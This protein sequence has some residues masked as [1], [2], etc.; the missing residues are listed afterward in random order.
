[1]K[2]TAAIG[3]ALAVV[4]LAACGST[5][6]PTA[7]PSTPTTPTPLLIS[8][9][10]PASSPSPSAPTPRPTPTP[11]PLPPSPPAQPLAMFASQANGNIELVNSQGKA[12]VMTVAQMQ[13]AVGES[14]ADINRE[15]DPT[16]EAAGPNILL[17]YLNGTPTA[18][19]AVISGSTGKLLGRGTAPDVSGQVVG[20]PSGTEWVWIQEIGVN[21]TGHYWGTVAIAGLGVSPHT[22]FNWTAPAGYN[23][24]LNYWTDAGIVLQ[25]VSDK[26]TCIESFADGNA[27]FLIN[28]LTG[29]STTL[30]SG[31]DQFILV[32]KEVQISSFW[33]ADNAVDIQGASYK[34]DIYSDEMSQITDG[35]HPSP[36]G[37]H[38]VVNRVGFDGTCNVVTSKDF[39]ELI[40]GVTETRV[41]LANI[42]ASG[43]LNDDDFIGGSPTTNGTWLYNLQGKPVQLLAGP[44]WLFQGV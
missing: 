9:P 34:A 15:Y 39:V 12:W 25:R 26:S 10:T 2:P 24:A 5:S 32:T 20:S 35:A 30:F 7:R 13:Q 8:T 29:T 43:W 4:S 28:P 21:S 16:A 17:T 40:D 18:V 1:M 22:I 42:Q 14:Q 23:E 36:D 41:D 3:A 38:V 19:I 27:A 44:S 6:T 37:V 33:G 11:T 31:Y